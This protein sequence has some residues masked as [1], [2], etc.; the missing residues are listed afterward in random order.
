M[1]GHSLVLTDMSR[2]CHSPHFGALSV[3]VEINLTVEGEAER[4]GVQLKVRVFVATDPK[5][6]GWLGCGGG[7]GGR[8][9]WG[10]SK[11]VVWYIQWKVHSGC[12]EN[13][14]LGNSRGSNDPKEFLWANFSDSHCQWTFRGL[15]TRLE[16]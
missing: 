1:I 11:A 15:S 14:V 13:F 3:D 6:R 16:L 2:S 8:G 7:G 5:M 4:F 10:W 9:W 12:L